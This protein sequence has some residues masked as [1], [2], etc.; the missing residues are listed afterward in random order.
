MGCLVVALPRR[1]ALLP[2]IVLTCYMTMGMRLIVAGMNFTM[3]RILLLFGWIR[4]VSRNELRPLRLNQ[5]DKAMIWFVLSSILTYALLWGNYDAFK[6]KLGLA[7]NVLGFYFFFRLVLKDQDDVVR[8]FKMFGVL[9]VPLAGLMIVEKVTGLNSFAIFGGVNAVTLVRDGALRCQ[10]PFAHPILAGT[11]GA[12]LVP[13]FVALW[14]DNQ[15]RRLN[16][17][18]AVLG[19]TSSAV[20]TAMCASSGPVLTFACG[21]FGMA[22]W[23]MRRYMRQIRWLTVLGLTGLHL[24][25]KAPVWFILARVDIFNA[26]TG[27]HRAYLIDR[28]IANFWDWWLVG[29]KS[30]AAW[31]DADQHLFDVTSQYLVYAADGGLI[32]MLLFIGIIVCGFRGVGRYIAAKGGTEQRATLICVWALGAALFAHVM[33]YLSTSY[34]D[35]NVV[36]WYLLLA[37]I[38]TVTGRYLLGK[39][40]ARLAARLLPNLQG[41]VASERLNVAGLRQGVQGGK[42]NPDLR[43]Q[44]LVPLQ[45]L[46]KLQPPAARMWDDEA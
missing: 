2:V 28:A 34:F 23:G 13:F 31:A 19:F 41:D 8:V 17:L 15:H 4:L 25:M 32:T 16:R 21:L 20:I 39:Q 37:M 27:Y 42:A 29:T 22:M 46:S 3:I 18:V 45:P 33:T 30:T 38:S 1:Y 44:G 36:T 43:E 12:A 40:P 35:Q 9:I 6:D 11:F 7:Y 14:F 24:V 26:S 10:G 5:I